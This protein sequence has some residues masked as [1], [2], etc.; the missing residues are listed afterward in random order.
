MLL[1][2]ARVSANP[3]M[4]RQVDGCGREHMYTAPFYEALE[5]P[6]FEHIR[7]HSRDQ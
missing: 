4:T 6:G 1:L 3:E 2:S 5:Y 7:L